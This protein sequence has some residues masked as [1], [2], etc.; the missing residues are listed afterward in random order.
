[1]LVEIL[2]LGPTETR[3]SRLKAKCNQGSITAEYDHSLSSDDKYINIA[4]EL[5]KKFNNKTIYESVSF[6]IVGYLNNKTYVH[7]EINY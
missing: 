6:K 4:M 3:G 5:F 1:M 7:I 2:F